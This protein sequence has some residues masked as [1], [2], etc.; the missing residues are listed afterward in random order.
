MKM[1]ASSISKSSVNNPVSFA[2][3]AVAYTITGNLIENNGSA[4]SVVTEPD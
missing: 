2:Q 1:L 4:S 3:N